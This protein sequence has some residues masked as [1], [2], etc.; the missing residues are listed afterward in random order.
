MQ[1]GVWYA[2]GAYVAWG[3]FPIYWKLVEEVPAVE[4]IGH[5][6][7]W[8][9][10]MLAGLLIVSR[11]LP[12]LRA[13]LRWPVVR[14]YSV[15]AVLIAVN[16]FT[17]VWAVTHGFI[18]E[19]SLGYFMNPLV[20]VVLGVVVL[21]ERL[22][23]GQ[24]LAVGLMAGGVTYLTLSYGSLP[25]IALV[26]ACSFGLYG[27][28]K[29]VAP[30]GAVH[31]LA[32]E[33]GLLL[34]PALAYLAVVARGGEGAFLHASPATELLL[35]GTGAVTIVPL[36]LFASAVR[37]ITL[38]LTGMLQFIAPTMQLLIGV[39]VYKEGFDHVRLVGFGLVW[40][41]LV[42]FGIEGALARRLRAGRPVMAGG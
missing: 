16:W 24:W 10:V 6:I 2:V 40:T 12:V 23:P 22:R 41:A 37:R 26:L 14:L 39:L 27:L 30:L 11:Q 29:K 20:S 1:R 33:T 15:A 5:R 18:V 42:L 8:S 28:V 21:R 34:V 13:A 31:G 19:T 7:V 36:M 17:Y 9:F 4:L 3:A 25:W 35:I 38:S 32:M